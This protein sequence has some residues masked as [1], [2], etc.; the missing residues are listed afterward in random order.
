MT[1]NPSIN[2]FNQYK[3]STKREGYQITFPEAI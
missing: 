3:Y 1:F 2:N